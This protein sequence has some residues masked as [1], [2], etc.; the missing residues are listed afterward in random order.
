MD[1]LILQVLNKMNET[2]NGCYNLDGF[3]VEEM[4]W[5]LIDEGCH[6]HSKPSVIQEAIQDLFD[7]IGC[8]EFGIIED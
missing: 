6:K 2:E 8:K 3:D 5:A 4:R 1:E 7:T